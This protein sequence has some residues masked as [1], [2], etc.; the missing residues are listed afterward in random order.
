[1]TDLKSCNSP[2]LWSSGI[3]VVTMRARSQSLGQLACTFVWVLLDFFVG[4]AL[5]YGSI[6]FEK[7]HVRDSRRL[8]PS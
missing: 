6:E 2:R 8:D 3:S 5:S 4:L 7:A 1:M